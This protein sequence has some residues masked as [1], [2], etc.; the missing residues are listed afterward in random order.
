MDDL[1]SVIMSVYNEPIEAVQPS[2][3]SILSQTYENWELIVVLDCPDNV[4]VK[5]YLR[6]TAEQFKKVS[7][8]VN[9]ANIGLGASLN[10]AVSVANGTFCAR[11]DAEDFSFKDRIQRQVNYVLRKPEIDLLFTQWQEIYSDG[12][13]KKRQPLSRDVRHIKKNFFIKSLLLHPTLLIRTDILK[14]HPYP[15]MDRPEDWVL[16]LDLIRFDYKFDLIEDI[17]YTYVV[18]E[19]QKYHK[20][21]TYS[22][23][24]LP[25]LLRNSLNYSTN[26]YY[27]LYFARIFGEFIISR[28]E[29]VYRKTSKLASSYWKK[30]FGSA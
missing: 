19:H 10:K 9:E 12:Q 26:I 11:M 29:Y 3:E 4:P 2:I 30:I 25:H 15:E 16:F 14:N 23:N 18:D 5:E 13:I 7:F 17:L 22:E 1:I 27:W 21:R 8:I 20:V 28:N 24:L 6:R